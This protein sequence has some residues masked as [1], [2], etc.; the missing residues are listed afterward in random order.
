MCRTLHNWF[1]FAAGSGIAPIIS[2]IKTILHR[3]T[4]IPVALIYSNASPATTIFYNELKTLQETFPGRLRIEFLFSS[5]AVVS[6]RRLN[7][8]MI[9]RI[10]RDYF[11]GKRTEGVP[12]NSIRKEIF[13]VERPV[14]KPVPPD[15]E[16]HHVLANIHNTAYTF[17]SQYPDTILQTA[18]AKGF[19][20]PYSCEAGQCGTCAATC[21]SGNV[22]MWRNDVLLDEEI[23]KGRILTCTGYAVGGDV[24]LQY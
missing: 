6:R 9:E 5:Y 22:W 16:S 10:A 8:A 19:S 23:A 1:F 13:N 3:S 20:L 4:N 11:S 17:S 21:I 7:V 24:V 12:E 2:L 14:N 18:K 15:I